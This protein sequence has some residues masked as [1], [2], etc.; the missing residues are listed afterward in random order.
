MDI[1]RAYTKVIDELLKN[2]FTACAREF[3]VSGGVALIALGGYGRGE[4]N[5]YSDVDLMLLYG[6]KLSPGIEAL[7]KKILYVLWDLKLDVGFGIRNVKECVDLAKNDIKT[8]TSLLD[9]RLILG[10]ESL[11]EELCANV[12]KKLFSGKNLESFIKEKVEEKELRHGK[13]GGS[14]YILEPNV[15]EGEGD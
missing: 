11:H 2:L 9:T 1:T 8:K 10:E 12:W 15:K 13:Y 3:G 5:I 7:T 6:K 14:V 4:L